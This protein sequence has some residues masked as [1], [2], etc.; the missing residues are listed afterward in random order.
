MVGIVGFKAP[1]VIVKPLSEIQDAVPVIFT[2]P[3][4]PPKPTEEEKQDQP[5]EQTSDPQV[6]MPQ[7]VTVAAVDSPDVAFS[8][9][10]PGAVAIAPVARLATPPPPTPVR[11][12]QPKPQQ[13][14]PNAARGEGS[15]PAPEYPGSAQ[16][17]RYQ[18]TVVIEIKVDEIGQITSATVYKSS[19]Y[20]I[21]DE[22]ALQVV[23]RRWR[24][25]PGP[26]RWLHW[27]CTFKMQ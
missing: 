2:P 24:F 11:K 4:E 5:E 19:G 20:T 25:T 21:L 18:G 7:V 15:F 6:D 12:E 8:V 26:P 9:P 17:N 14:N 16:R 23:Q 13:F 3:E 22:A 1:K 27:P 10:V